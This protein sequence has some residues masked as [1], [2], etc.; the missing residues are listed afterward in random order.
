MEPTPST[1]CGGIGPNGEFTTNKKNYEQ[2]NSYN[3]LRE[4]NTLP[5]RP[6][7]KEHS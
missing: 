4:D 1:K 2:G 6:I 7:R 3:K 5:P